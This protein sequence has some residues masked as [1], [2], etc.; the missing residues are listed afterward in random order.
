MPAKKVKTRSKPPRPVRVWPER[1]DAD[2]EEVMRALMR[3]PRDEIREEPEECRAKRQPMRM[4]QSANAFTAR[5]WALDRRIDREISNL[6]NKIDALGT[7]PSDAG[8]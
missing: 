5:S 6:S 3:T 7:R 1:I 2:P 4:K 8:R